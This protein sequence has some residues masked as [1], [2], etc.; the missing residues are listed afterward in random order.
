M[1]SVHSTPLSVTNYVARHC[2]K[3]S[4]WFALTLTILM[5]SCCKLFS[6]TPA[7]NYQNRAS[8][9]KVIK[10]VKGVKFFCPRVYIY[11]YVCIQCERK[12]PDPPAQLNNF[13]SAW[14]IGKKLL[15]LPEEPILHSSTKF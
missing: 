2:S 15:E 9:D 1:F 11:L 6:N 4:I 14:T 8:F 10:K 13:S 5:S 3:C 12:K 7:K